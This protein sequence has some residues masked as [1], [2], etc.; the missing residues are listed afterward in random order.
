MRATIIKSFY[1]RGAQSVADIA[2]RM[3]KSIPSITR[4]INELLSEEILVENGHAPST[5]GRRAARYILNKAN[6]PCFVTIAIDQYSISGNIFDI[7]NTALCDSVSVQSDFQN[8]SF[9]DKLC[10]SIQ[11]LLDKSK[12]E[13]KEIGNIALTIPGFVNYQT[14]INDSFPSD[15]PFYNLPKR[16]EEVFGKEAYVQNDSSA[17]ATAESIFGAARDISDALIINFN[18]GVGLGIIVENRLFTGHNG[19]AGEF[20][21]IPLTHSSKLCSCGKR[22]CLEVEASLLAAIEFV[23]QQVK[24]GKTSILSS[25][26]S[27]NNI[28]KKGEALIQAA[29]K[30]DQLAIN[31]ANKSAFMLGKGIATLIHILN[32]EKIIISG[33]GAQ[34]GALILP[35]IQSA[36]NE[37]AIP[38]LAKQSKIEISKNPEVIQLLGTVCLAVENFNWSN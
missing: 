20:S 12:V 4:V 24:E 23:E 8:P 29:R 14:G 7:H 17:I 26:P 3:Q 32:P 15:S 21:H 11:S 25:L 9:F 31:A 10:Q 34:F 16:I 6:T 18:W 33:R 2:H 30:G 1:F 37:F 35:Q 22:G 28:P 19:F 13:K 5:G 27:C 38:K 36:I